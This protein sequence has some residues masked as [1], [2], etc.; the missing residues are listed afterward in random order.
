MTVRP[1]EVHG[2]DW[3]P[4]SCPVR[5][6]SQGD[7]QD[8]LTKQHGAPPNAVAVTLPCPHFQLGA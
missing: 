2:Q 8:R 1:Q 3:R 7:I 4:V 6:A 5:A